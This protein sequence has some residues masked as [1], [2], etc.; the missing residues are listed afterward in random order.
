MPKPEEISPL[1]KDL[2]RKKMLLAAILLSLLPLAAPAQEQK[3]TLAQ[4]LYVKSGMEK[5]LAQI[6]FIIQTGLDQAAPGNSRLRQVPKDVLATMRA[7]AP[8]AFAPENLKKTM[9]K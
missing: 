3:E 6:P 4:E 2:M 1:R 7:L 8:T 5:Q 9:V